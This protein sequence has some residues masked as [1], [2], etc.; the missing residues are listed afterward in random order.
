MVIT[1]LAGGIGNQMFQY[2]AGH[3]LAARLRSKFKIDTSRYEWD[4]YRKLEIQN[5]KITA[6]KANTIERLAY[7]APTKFPINRLPAYLYPVTYFKENSTAFDTRS[8]S[9]SG[10][11]YMVGTWHSYKYFES[12]T[13]SIRKEFRFRSR[14]S[15]PG[16]NIVREIN[17][18]NAVSIHVRRGDYVT[19]AKFSKVHPVQPISYYQQSIRLVEQRVKNPKYFI[20]S[21]DIGWCR[22]NLDIDNAVFVSEQTKS[23]IEDLELMTHCQHAIIANSSFSWWGAWLITNQRKFVIAPKKWFADRSIVTKDIYLPEWKVI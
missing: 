17:K 7:S 10:N 21:D 14:F 3:A 13:D 20:F 8:K 19:S 4:K 12:V 22:D 23:G 11:I 18:S 9:L 1:Q 15:K 16:Q 5:L 2:A 6:S